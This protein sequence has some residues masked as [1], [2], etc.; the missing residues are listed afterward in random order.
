MLN[1]QTRNGLVSCSGLE[2]H[3]TL[4]RPWTAITRGDFFAGLFLIG[5]ANGLAAHV[6]NSIAHDGWAEA[7]LSTFGTSV[8]VWIACYVG[9]AFMLRD[10]SDSIQRSDLALGLPL[11]AIMALPVGGLSWVGVT[12][13]ALYV[14]LCTNRSSPRQRGAIILLATAVSVLWSRLLFAFL[15][16]PIL[17][18]DA[19]LTA[20]LKGT[21]RVGNMVRFADNSGYLVILPGCSS[22]GNVSL[23][24]LTWVL[25]SQS[26][27]HRWSVRDIFWCLLAC[28]SVILVNVSRL[29]LM[30][31]DMNQF[32]TIHNQWGNAVANVI[33]LTLIVSIS[34]L[35]VRRELLS[36]V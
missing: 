16:K 4:I 36:R 14:I 28:A 17:D 19:T 34:A 26:V 25:V 10:R 21:P 11:L 27:G 20:W 33:I 30:A 24:F 8:I 9:I 5:C 1:E 23:A 7:L 22:F 29:S 32:A 35:S 3:G 12:A 2:P 6:I 31:T 15:C 18:I 13:L